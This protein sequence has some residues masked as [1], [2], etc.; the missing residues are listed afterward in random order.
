M[1]LVRLASTAAFAALVTGCYTLR[2]VSGVVP[3]IGSEVAFDVNDAGRVALGGT[4]GPEIAQIEGRVVSRDQGDF[5]LSVSAIRLLRGGEQ[6]WRGEQVR[7]K[8]EYLGN[9]YERRFSRGRTLVLSAAGIGSFAYLL[10]RTLFASGT[11]D[12]KTVPD[13]GGPGTANRVP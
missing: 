7:L 9:A 4:M 10:T 13:P 1:R 8:S 2:P 3:E 5:T 11:E 12:E 6:V